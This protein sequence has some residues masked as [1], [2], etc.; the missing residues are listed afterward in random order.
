MLPLKDPRIIE[1]ALSNY[2]N[3]IDATCS[4]FN[5]SDRVT[6]VYK[7]IEK[8]VLPLCKTHYEVISSEVLW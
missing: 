5:C 2:I 7:T 8:R 1:Q 3:K 6:D 4:I